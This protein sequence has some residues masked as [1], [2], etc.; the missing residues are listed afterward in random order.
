MF[1]TPQNTARLNSAQKGIQVPVREWRGGWEQHWAEGIAV[2][3]EVGGLVLTAIF[4]VV[5][6]P[7]VW[8]ERSQEVMRRHRRSL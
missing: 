5:F 4:L 2:L 1:L 8:S 6:Q 7:F 3:P